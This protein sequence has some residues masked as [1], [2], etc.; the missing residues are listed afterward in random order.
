MCVTALN[1]VTAINKNIK[2]YH[3]VVNCTKYYLNMIRRLFRVS[4]L[5]FLDFGILVIYIYIYIYIFFLF[6]LLY[7]FCC[8]FVF[9]M[10]PTI[11]NFMSS[12]RQ[13]AKG[14]LTALV[15]R[16]YHVFVNISILWRYLH[17]KP[18]FWSPR[19][20]CDVFV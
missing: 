7:L 1:E 15:E 14:K 12:F 17:S 11:G 4:N 19:L 3:N 2:I 6:C 10:C 16:S 9:H 18:R 20:F 8:L 5:T 13:K